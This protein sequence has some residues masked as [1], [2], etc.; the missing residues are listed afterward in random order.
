MSDAT[1]DVLV[2]G[3]GING[4]GVAQAAA[5]AGHRT[6]LLEKSSLGYGTSSRSSKL[7][8]GG[9]R[10]LESYEFSLVR[11]SLHERALMLKL[12]PELVKLKPFFIPVYKNTRRG[13]LLVRAGLSLYALLGGM[14]R[15]N[16][17]RKVP[18]SEWGNLD[19]L[20]TDDLRAVYQYFDG[21]TDDQ[22]LT[23]AVMHSAATVGAVAHVGAHFVGGELNADGCRV[24]YRVNDTEHEIQARVV[25]N[26]AGPW[27]NPVLDAITPTPP[28]LKV[29]LVQG[30][31]I[32][33]NWQIDRG[34]YYVEAPRDGRAVF[35]MPREP[36]RALV[37][38]TEVKFT[39]NPDEVCALDTEIRYLQNVVGH[40]FPEGHDDRSVIGTTTG[41]RVLPTGEG[42]AFSRSRETIYHPDRE[43]KPRLLT[44]YGGKLTA[45]RATA[46]EAFARI[47]QSLPARKPVANTETMPLPPAP[48]EHVGGRTTGES[49]NEKSLA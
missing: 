37:G 8:H 43:D 1:T 49:D 29:D 4:T 23:R 28:K 14:D 45:W 12:A 25:V 9:L 39:G 15:D 27:A 35:M 19:G 16:R 34:I 2:V 17:F 11:E 5:A 30:T 44:I 20:V 47:E 40:Y 10:Y 26:A 48:H 18:R 24:R 7:V 42:H 21:Q 38:T 41:L 32:V 13:P 3:G 31:H 36:G 6:V 22:E 33:M 46:E